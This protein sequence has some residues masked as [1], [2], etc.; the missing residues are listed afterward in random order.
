MPPQTI[1][2]CLPGGT[3]NKVLMKPS[4][5]VMT[6][7]FNL[8]CTLDVK[9][10]PTVDTPRIWMFNCC[11]ADLAFRD[12]TRVGARYIWTNKQVDLIQSVLDRVFV[13][14]E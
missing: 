2:S 11:I 1:V 3:G 14:I 8:I 9:S 6:S 12:V 13:C 7:D 5:V 10:S 4:S